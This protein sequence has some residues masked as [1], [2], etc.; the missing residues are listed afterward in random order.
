MSKHS[1]NF[2]TI[3]YANESKYSISCF[4]TFFS[5]ATLHSIFFIYYIII[6]IIMNKSQEA[7]VLRSPETD[8]RHETEAGKVEK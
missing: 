4:R 8:F 2:L 7:T 1:D 3:S 6:I 5:L